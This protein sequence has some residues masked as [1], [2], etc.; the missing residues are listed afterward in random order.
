MI[1]SIL[2]P[3]HISHL[4]FLEKLLPYLD[5]QIKECRAEKR[6]EVLNLI[7]KGEMSTGAK[8]NLLLKKAKGK[9][10]SF[11]DVDDWVAPYFIKEFLRAARSGADCVA[12]NG[13]MTTDGQKGIK[14]FLGKDLF[15]ETVIKDGEAV[16][17]R[18]TNH[19]TMT[20]RKLALQAGFTDKYNG[21]DKDYSVALN[22]F[23]MTEYTIEPPMYWY[24][25]ISKNKLY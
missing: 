18:T 7:D 25:Y 3:V 1:L 12:I 23:L 4:Y 22:P 20:K 11:V 8:R 16:Y 19:I 21:E 9:F 14:W 5:E 6:V 2:I 10:I 13:W 17:L 15:N 24:R